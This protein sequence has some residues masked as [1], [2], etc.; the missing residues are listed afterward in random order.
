MFADGVE[1]RARAERPATDEE[2]VNLVRSVIENRRRDGQLND[3]P[4]RAIVRQTV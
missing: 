1:A 4:G 2:M 3:A